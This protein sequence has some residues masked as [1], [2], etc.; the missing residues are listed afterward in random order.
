MAVDRP[1]GQ[2]PVSVAEP[3]VEIEIANPESVSVETPDGGMLIDFDPQAG[4]EDVSHDANLAEHLEESD[5]RGVA[6]ELV[7]AYQSDRAATGKKPISTAWISWASST[8]TE[9]FPGMARAV[10]FIR[11]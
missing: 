2:G 10:Y 5:L 1:L 4:E 3:S 9:P 6:S 7:S 11:C 8:K